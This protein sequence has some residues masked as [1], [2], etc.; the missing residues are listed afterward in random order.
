VGVGEGQGALPRSARDAERGAFE[1]AGEGG[2]VSRRAVLGLG[3][4]AAASWL[5]AACSS[6]SGDPGV[7]PASEGLVTVGVVSDF[8]VGTAV[9]VE[10][11]PVVVLHDSAGLFAL[12]AVC[13]HAGCT[14][15]VSGDRLPCPCHGS[16]FATD[17]R[18]L[19][20]PATS[21]LAHLLVTVED[22]DTVLVDTAVVVPS[23]QRT[24][25]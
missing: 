11:P 18:V 14:V 12:T 19:Q 20:G 21:P 17:G 4:G 16:V 24:P 1:R 3:T 15:G 23:T 6:G 9:L 13:S 7:G 2:G 22:G 5:L 25:V 10:D 8:P